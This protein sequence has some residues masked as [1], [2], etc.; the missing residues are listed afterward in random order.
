MQKDHCCIHYE[1]EHRNGQYVDYTV[2]GIEYGTCH[3]C[4]RRFQ[5]KR[6][7]VVIRF[8]CNEIKMEPIINPIP[9]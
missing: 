5:H 8:V 7:V 1:V 4:Y 6:G 9:F 3:K 2:D